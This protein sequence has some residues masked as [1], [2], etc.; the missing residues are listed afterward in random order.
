MST[1]NTQ[2][3]RKMTAIAILAAL[4]AVLQAISIFIG[5]F[6]PVVSFTLALVPIVVG[7]VLYGPWAGAFLGAVMGAVVFASVVGGQ[8]GALSTAMLQYSPIVTFIACVF[9]TTAA[10]LVSGAVYKAISKTGKE[11]LAII[12]AAILCPIVNTGIFLALLLTVFYGIASSFASGG[13]F[14][15]VYFVFVLIL[16]I[17]FV[18]EFVLNS[19]LSPVIVRII[20][21]LRKNKLTK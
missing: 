16:G 15:M 8:A 13:N 14:T 6:N 19:A 2:K 17:N 3:I 1:A 11:K 12:I 20:E 9:K 7:A 4:V 10:G 5:Q 18:I 21:V